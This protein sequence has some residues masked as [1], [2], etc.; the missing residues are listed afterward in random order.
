MNEWKNVDK[1]KCY[2]QNI[3]AD[4]RKLLKVNIDISILRII[5][6]VTKIVFWWS[7][8]NIEIYFLLWINVTGF[9]EN[10]LQFQTCH[11]QLML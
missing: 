9:V 3:N 5:S 11:G 6:F 4:E 2:S 1:E 10:H 8:C 7:N